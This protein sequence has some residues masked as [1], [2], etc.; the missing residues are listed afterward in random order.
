MMKIIHIVFITIFVFKNFD[1]GQASMI[2]KIMIISVITVVK[3]IRLIKTMDEK[4]LTSISIHLIS[5]KMF[6]TCVPLNQEAKH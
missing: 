4:A 6:K 3:T 1:K 2:R 5:A